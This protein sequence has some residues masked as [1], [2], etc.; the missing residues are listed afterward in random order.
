MNELVCV[1]VVVELVEGM[2]HVHVHAP[3]FR[4]VCKNAYTEC[5]VTP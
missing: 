3:V 4:A 2:H 1:C 5:I